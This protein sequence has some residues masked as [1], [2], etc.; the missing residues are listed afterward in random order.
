VPFMFSRAGSFLALLMGGIGLFTAPAANATT[1]EQLSLEQM[2]RQSTEI[3]RGKM[4]SSA[5][6]QRNGVIYT[7]SRFQVVERWK[8]NA[9][10]TVEV[11]LPGGTLGKLHQTFAGAP[12]LAPGAEYVLFL[13]T[14]KSGITRRVF[15][16]CRWTPRASR[17]WRGRQQRRPCWVPRV[18]W[19]PTRRCACRLL[20]WTGP[21]AR[22]WEQ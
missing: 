8:G 20:S 11:V 15:L 5:P 1:L 3:V 4:V 12:V 6:E 22:P 9:S 16:I 10:A 19:Y 21:S 14:G 7:R 18:K 2:A 13:W 17:R